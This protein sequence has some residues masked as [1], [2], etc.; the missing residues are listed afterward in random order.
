MAEAVV[1]ARLYGTE[2]VDRALFSAAVAGR[3]AESDLAAILQHQRNHTSLAPIRASE[4]HSLQPG[5]SAWT[6]FGDRSLT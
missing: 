6:G 2:P 4:D 5:T 3:F 1:L